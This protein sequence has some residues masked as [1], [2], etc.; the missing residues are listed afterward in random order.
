MSNE[1]YEN[2]PMP[3][4]FDEEAQYDQD[5]A[6]PAAGNEPMDQ[7]DRLLG[8]LSNIVESAPTVPLSSKRMI[9]ADMCLRIIDNIYKCLPV[10]IRQAQQIL[11]ERDQI[12]HE[13]EKDASTK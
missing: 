2:Q 9:N 6:Q 11:E 5:G 12:I 8:Y 10:A 13:A 1:N 3:E 7:L 4:E